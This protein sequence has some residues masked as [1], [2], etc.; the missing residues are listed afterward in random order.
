MVW[1]QQSAVICMLTRTVEGEKR[2]AD[3]YWPDNEEESSVYGIYIIYVIC[4]LLELGRVAV[5]LK[6]M[7]KLPYITIRV[8]T[9]RRLDTKEE[10]DV[11]HLHYTEWPDFGE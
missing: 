6:S 4:D 5:T 1:E 2:K 10:R 3:V 7:S 11:V 9:L 8:L